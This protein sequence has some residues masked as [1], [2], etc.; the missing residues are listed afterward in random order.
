MQSVEWQELTVIEVFKGKEMN[1]HSVPN[2]LSYSWLI[3]ALGQKT[4][5]HILQSQNYKIIVI[6]L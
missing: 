3:L 2:F 1:A 6:H 4:E 5:E